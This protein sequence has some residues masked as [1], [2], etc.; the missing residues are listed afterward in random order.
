M[1]C[2]GAFLL[3][4]GIGMAIAAVVAAWMWISRIPGDDHPLSAEEIR[5]RVVEAWG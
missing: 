5:R 3:G 1:N 2:T 4:I